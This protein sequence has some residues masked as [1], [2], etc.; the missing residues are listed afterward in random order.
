VLSAQRAAIASI[1]ATVDIRE[2]WNVEFRGQLGVGFDRLL[3]N[4]PRCSHGTWACAGT[5][6]RLD[7]TRAGIDGD[8]TEAWDGT[9][10]TRIV[11]RTKHAFFD[12]DSPLLGRPRPSFILGQVVDAP[13]PEF[14]ASAKQFSVTIE[15]DGRV[16]SLRAVADPYDVCLRVTISPTIAMTSC[17]V[18]GIQSKKLIETYAWR[19]H[20]ETSSGVCLPTCCDIVLYRDKEA[21]RVW[22]QRITITLSDVQVNTPIPEEYFRPAPPDGYTLYDRRTLRVTPGLA[23]ALEEVGADVTPPLTEPETPPVNEEHQDTAVVRSRRVMTDVKTNVA[24]ALPWFVLAAA[25]LGLGY[26]IYRRH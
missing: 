15:G 2:I 16:A 11:H 17:E 6:V 4:M 20:T 22:A 13:L 21:D 25:L 14:V 8:A 3:D 26:V 19:S 1:R 12:N 23:P 9:V 18:R 24:A 5:K 7:L 10:G